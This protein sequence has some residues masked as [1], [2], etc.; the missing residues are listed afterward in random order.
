LLK[1]ISAVKRRL[2][3]ENTWKHLYPLRYFSS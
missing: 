2:M 1:H 3:N